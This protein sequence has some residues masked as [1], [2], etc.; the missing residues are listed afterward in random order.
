[1]NNLK[2]FE[3]LVAKREGKK[4]ST[5]IGNIREIIKII[6]D[7]VIGE[8]RYDILLILL[9]KDSLLREV[10]VE[11]RQAVGNFR[12]MASPHE[13]Y[14]VIKEELDELWEAIRLKQSNPKRDA[15]IRA[16]AIQVAAMGLRFLNDCCAKRS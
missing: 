1:M 14:A 10:L 11:L 7:E 15:R 12:P 4:S 13:G 5:S 9:R 3:S 8:K 6:R 16:E 2:Q